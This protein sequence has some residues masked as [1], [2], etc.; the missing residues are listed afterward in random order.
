M[1]MNTLL[2]S[3]LLASLGL[4][5]TDYSQA[6]GSIFNWENDNSRNSI[7][8]AVTNPDGSA[9]DYILSQRGCTN[10]QGY[11]THL[12]DVDSGLTITYFDDKSGNSCQDN[13]GWEIEILTVKQ[14]TTTD[15]V[16]RMSYSAM[17]GVPDGQLIVP[18]VMKKRFRSGGDI[19]GKISCIRVERK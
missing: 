17:A 5:Q 16:S 18:G 10:D 3:G 1:N 11:T 19:G 2:V 8:P 4:I 6:E 13:A 9:K 7:V 15:A 14:P 12:V